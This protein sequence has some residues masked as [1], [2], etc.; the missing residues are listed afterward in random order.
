[1]IVIKLIDLLYIGR[2]NHFD[3][4]SQ[5]FQSMLKLYINNYV[6]WL[7]RFSLLVIFPVMLFAATTAQAQKLISFTQF[8]DNI[9]PFNPAYSLLDKAGSLSTVY[10]KQ[11][12][13]IQNGA[14]TTF[15]FNANFPIEPI[16]GAAGIIIQNNSVG[17]ETLTGINLFFAK[18]VQ[19]TDK[20]F[21][22][23]S[24]NGG[25]RKY[26][27]LDPDPTDPTFSDIRETRLNAGFGAM[28]YSDTYY[29]GI[30][31]PELTFQSLGT[32]TYQNPTDIEN[33]Y[34]IT[35]AILLGNPDDDFKFK[36]AALLAYSSGAPV[37]ASVSA[38]LYIKD[39]LGLGV[40]YRSDNFA[41][42]M[43]SYTFDYFRIGYS[44]QF[45]TGG[46]NLGGISAATNEVT[47]SYRFGSGTLN[48]KLL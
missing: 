10:S 21:L 31:V 29:I 45:G 39:M 47:L 11:F 18:S 4:L 14:P 17:P 16:N 44:Y 2:S 41:S 23:V 1:M 48:P 5:Y 34:Y 46:N 25:F 8:S 33:H 3:K 42:A 6:S 13:E 37:L 22:S 12:T 20:D 15:L 7:K 36:P 26:V 9:T 32:A 38:T 27:F 43:L 30:S 24:L 35:G 19:L 40:G 28:L